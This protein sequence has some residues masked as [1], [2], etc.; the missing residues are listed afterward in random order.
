MNYKIPST[1][2]ALRVLIVEDSE[3][4]ALMIRRHLEK[5]GFLVTSE[6]VQTPAAFYTALAD[7]E[8]D[9]VLSDYSLPSFEAPA[10]L[11]ILQQTNLDIPFVI[12]SGTMGEETAV[13]MMRAG[14]ADYLMK[15]NL[16]RLG[17][18]IHREIV[19]A[20]GRRD[21]SNI[22]MALR[23]S[24]HRRRLAVE[25]AR[26]GTW[27]IDFTP[28][29]PHLIMSDVGKMLCGVIPDAEFAW[30]ELT[31]SI[32]RNDRLNVHAAIKS[33]FQTGQDTSIE[34][35]ISWP[36]GSEHWLVSHASPILEDG[37]RPSRLIGVTQDVTE[38]KERETE[39]EM[40]LAEAKDRADRDPLTGLW[41]HTAFQNRLHSE[42]A[43]AWRERTTLA[44]V[45]LDLNNFKFF[46]D[47][48]GYTAGN[49]VLLQLA[50][51]L[52]SISRS[53]D[54]VARFGG[55]EFA[56]LLPSVRQ[57]NAADLEARLHTDIGELIFQPTDQVSGIPI[58]VSIGAAL[59]SP[60]SAA[61]QATYEQTIRQAEER[62]RRA[63]AGINAESEADEIR[64]AMRNRVDDFSMLDALV[65]SVDNKDRY[66]RR[67]SED[68]MQ[69]SLII[70]QGLGFTPAE[71]HTV[72]VAAL[73]HDVGKIGVPDSILRKPGT[74]TEEEFEAVKRHPTMGAVMVTA[75]AGLEDTLDAVRHHHERWDGGGYPFGL[76]GEETPL[77]A[78]L[79]AVADAFSAM[80]TDRPYRK[81]MPREKAAAILAEGSGTQ[82]APRCVEVFLEALPLFLEAHPERKGQRSM[83]A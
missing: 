83:L 43:R 36:D 57:V 24:E 41:N 1:A 29:P 37:E 63:K 17:A 35:R 47:A 14:A 39:R 64:R 20:K 4:D 44:V 23:V 53:Y 15:S 45:L 54:T 79:M 66:T 33:A 25:G 82:W 31:K 60:D 50:D 27:E 40:Q 42:V 65:T 56:L 71:Q 7:R 73:L 48:Y 77:I 52:K 76:R 75:A 9:I 16:R 38:R 18:V 70:A 22:D 32:H 21:R 19:E 26:L 58:T 5:S 2:T 51:R 6:R 28:D 80:T 62:M 3:D 68:V 8:W 59:F 81:G 12:I 61:T 49:K 30:T 78:R 55:D 46:N 69:Y 67:H 72:A 13:D 11:A 74:L 34:Y 10:A